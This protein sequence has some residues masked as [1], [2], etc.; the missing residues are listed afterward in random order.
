[1]TKNISKKQKLSDLVVERGLASTKRDAISLIL[2]GEVLVNGIIQDKAGV[3]FS[4]SSIITVKATQQFASR[5]GDKLEGAIMHFSVDFKDRIVLDIGASTGGFTDCVLSHGAKLVY[6]VD[7]GT[8]QLDWA[9]RNNQ[10]VICMEGVN[11]R[12]LD[13]ISNEKFYPS[14]TIAVMDLSF[15]SVRQVIM[16]VVRKLEPPKE[17]L[18]LVKPQFEL[19]REDVEDGGVISDIKKQIEAVRLVSDFVISQGGRCSEP[20]ASL[21]KGKRKGNQEYFLMIGF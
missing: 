6:A 20:F 19:P 13:E 12:L 1:M 5:G 18:L 3:A 21:V 14:P 9:L 8:N 17:I 16:P 15:I 2:A 11:A 10:H 4:Q 7:V